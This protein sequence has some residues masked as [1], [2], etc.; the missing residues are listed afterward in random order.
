MRTIPIL[1]AIAIIGAMAPLTAAAA[2]ISTI[3]TA[4]YAN[5]TG[6]SVSPADAS[7]YNLGGTYGQCSASTALTW[8][9]CTWRM[10]FDTVITDV[11]LKIIVA[12]TLGSAQN[13]QLDI[14]VN[15][16]LAQTLSTTVLST[17]ALNSYSYDANVAVSA[18]DEVQLRL[19]NPTWTTNPTNVLY[20]ALIGTTGTS[21][22]DISI[23]GGG[24][25]S[26]DPL[27][28]TVLI[29][30]LWLAVCAGAIALIRKFT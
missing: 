28:G 25:G 1:A 22:V 18:G 29:A 20:Q 17:A 15:N 3:D 26:T 7:T 11:E 5:N 27:I 8:S 6:G 24:G 21:T 2:E 12:G 13:S 30:F 9:T 4:A 10:P 19:V 16:S 23:D 14:Y